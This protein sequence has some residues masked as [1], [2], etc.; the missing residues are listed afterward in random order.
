MTR[1][2][3]AALGAGAAA[4]AAALTAAPL[5]GQ[6][7]TVSG[8]PPAIAITT[9]SGPG[10]Q[11]VAVTNATTTYSVAR[12]LSVFNTYRITAGLGAALPTGVTLEIQLAAPSGATSQGWV[13]LTTTAK[14]VVTG[15]T[16]D[17]SGLTVQYRL[18]A[19]TEAGRIP[20]TSRAV[21]LSLVTP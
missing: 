1:G 2:A 10:G 16:N 3:R 7:V 19:T 4:L 5:G 14:N 12:G 21:T 8:S 15:I 18:S 9:A 13:T 11:P 20:S 6:S 17:G